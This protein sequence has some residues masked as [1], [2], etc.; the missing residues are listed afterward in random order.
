MLNLMT[1]AKLLLTAAPIL[2]YERP[3]RQP[4]PRHEHSVGVYI[5]V[6]DI[7]QAALETDDPVRYASMLDVLT[8][9]E[10]G[11]RLSAVGD[12]GASCGV[13]QCPCA[14]TPGFA[15]CTADEVDDHTRCHHGWAFHNRPGLALAQARK[16]I[17]ILQT[18]VGNCPGHPIFRYA[19]GQC[20]WSRTASLYEVDV[21]AEI[22]QLMTSS[23]QQDQETASSTP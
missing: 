11:G 17:H 13:A 19:S 2:D 8:L 15:R 14:E 16:A 18:S 7:A 20:S 4:I 23:V 21:N 3:V 22:N 5:G 12:S 1:L 6:D 10:S 9:H